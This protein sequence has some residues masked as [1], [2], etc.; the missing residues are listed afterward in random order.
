M[1]SSWIHL[2]GLL[3]LF[4]CTILSAGDAS[5]STRDATGDG[6]LAQDQCRRFPPHHLLI[7]TDKV[8][9]NY[10]KAN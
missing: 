5:P 2:L 1:P 4:L 10:L 6:I 7:H 3:A 8:A 9:S